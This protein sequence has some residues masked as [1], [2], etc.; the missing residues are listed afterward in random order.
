MEMLHW[1]QLRGAFEAAVEVP[2]ESR[3]AFV[4]SMTLEPAVRE[5]LI[6]M[7]DADAR[8]HRASHGGNAGAR[9]QRLL[10]AIADVT[11]PPKDMASVTPLR[12]SS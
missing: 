6:A 4:A 10:R 8:N 9:L 2:P 7:L 5:E 12:R 3:D 1:K 11:A